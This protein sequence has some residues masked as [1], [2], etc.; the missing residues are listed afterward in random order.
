MQQGIKPKT[1]KA[2]AKRFRITAKGKFKHAHTGKRHLLSCKSPKRRR[3][4]RQQVLVGPTD[5]A[6]IKKNLPYS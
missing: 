1:R 2:V 6:R 4:L 3:R 5:I